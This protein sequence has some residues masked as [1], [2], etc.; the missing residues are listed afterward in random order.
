MS[1]ETEQ[2]GADA[3][4]HGSTQRRQAAF[5]KAFIQDLRQIRAAD[6]VVAGDQSDPRGA[7]LAGTLLDDGRA[8]LP[9]SDEHESIVQNLLTGSSPVLLYEYRKDPATNDW[10]YELDD[11][12]T[13]RADARSGK[14]ILRKFNFDVAVTDGGPCLVFLQGHHRVD[15]ATGE[16]DSDCHCVMQDGR[17]RKRAALELNRRQEFCAALCNAAVPAD[18]GKP[19]RRNALIKVGQAAA[20]SV[21]QEELLT[22]P[23]YLALA[24]GGDARAAAKAVLD[25]WTSPEVDAS[26]LWLDDTWAKHT[27]GCDDLGDATKHGWLRFVK[28]DAGKSTDVVAARPAWLKVMVVGCNIDPDDPRSLLESVAAKEAQVQTPPS[29]LANQIV[30]ILTA[31]KNPTDP[32]SAPLYNRT[33]VAQKFGKSESVLRNYE[34]IDQLVDEVKGMIDGG[35]MPINF[36]VAKRESAFAEWPSKG[37]QKGQRTV[38]PPDKQ[39]LVLA[40]LLAEADAAPEGEKMRFSGAD[41]S[42][43]MKLGKRLRDLALDGKLGPVGA[44]P[45]PQID[46]DGNEVEPDAAPAPPAA[47]K[48]HAPSG[49]LGPMPGTKPRAKRPQLDLAQYREHLDRAIAANQA[50]IDADKTPDSATALATHT[51]GSNLTLARALMLVASG[52]EPVSHLSYWPEVQAA[53][54]AALPQEPVAP[55]PAEDELLRDWVCAAAGDMGALGL[56]LPVVT[57]ATESNGRRPTEVQAAACNEQIAAYVR[58]FETPGKTEESSIDLYCIARATA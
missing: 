52:A 3:P 20:R 50:V 36:A 7:A 25:G 48:P 42:P 55:E 30:R 23:K 51:L 44:A 19:G 22:G 43:A 29:I 56:D 17:Q 34:L 45:E 6:V 35:E 54:V 12:G 4:D 14:P 32:A 21:G 26:L 1:T 18:R 47:G 24:P 31:P 9:W 37:P 2:T 57:T 38:L 5:S 28:D 10:V 46:A 16:T 8:M 53:F 49:N 39:R 41:G 11:A 33:A 40:H 58:D 13:V 27:I 15:P